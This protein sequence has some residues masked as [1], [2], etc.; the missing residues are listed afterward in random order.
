MFIMLSGYP[1]FYGDDDDATYLAIQKEPLTFRPDYW[2]E[3]PADMGGPI[4]EDAIDFIRKMCERDI[5]TRWTAVQCVDHP[6]IQRAKLP[7][8][9]KLSPTYL[10]RLAD[11]LSPKCPALKRAAF[12]LIINRLSEKEV[13]EYKDLF[14]TLDHDGDGYVVGADI[15]KAAKEVGLDQEADCLRAVGDLGETRV[16]YTEFMAAACD[17]LA[18][19]TELHIISAFRVFD[20]RNENKI[21][22]D[23]LGSIFHDPASAAGDAK[24][25]GRSLIKDHDLNKDGFLDL[26]EFT[27]MVTAATPKE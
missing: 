7:F 21:N 23:T 9:S 26:E 16:P 14:L 18:C 2:A 24:S 12:Q 3:R 8:N 11:Y 15:V 25:V 10:S 17:K 6:W 19:A 27:K 5:R 4:S 20:R 13:K 1:P 22:E